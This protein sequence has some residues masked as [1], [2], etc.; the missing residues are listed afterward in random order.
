M[1]QLTMS[2]TGQCKPLFMRENLMENSLYAL[3]Q[4]AL[5]IV[6]M[7]CFALPVRA[8]SCVPCAPP[9]TGG[10]LRHLAAVSRQVAL[11]EERVG[12]STSGNKH[13]TTDFI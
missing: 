7:S 10:L 8:G 9:P 13:K 2:D 11:Y 4:S 3:I 1:Q 12:H 5:I 6:H